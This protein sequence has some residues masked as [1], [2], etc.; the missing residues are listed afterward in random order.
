MEYTLSYLEQDR[1][2]DRHLNMS[3]ES[4]KNIVDNE[5]TVRIRYGDEYIAVSMNIYRN[6]HRGEITSGRWVRST[7]YRID[8][9][10]ESRIV[11]TVQEGSIPLKEKTS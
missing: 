7:M 11:G 5:G 10:Y 6:F 8:S 2:V 3:T 4:L 1:I 9:R